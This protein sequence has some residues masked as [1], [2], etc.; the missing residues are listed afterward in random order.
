MRRV[1]RRGSMTAAWSQMTKVFSCP[2]MKMLALHSPS[3]CVHVS[4]MHTPA[5]ARSIPEIKELS[6]QVPQR[7]CL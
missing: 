2:P 1:T 7:A 3:S 6:L 4:G 5:H